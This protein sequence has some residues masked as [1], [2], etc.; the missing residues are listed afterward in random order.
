MANIP[1][2]PNS[3]TDSGPPINDKEGGRLESNIFE[4][5][6]TSNIISLVFGEFLHPPTP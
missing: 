6:F 2:T 1:Q 4:E 3:F 5:L